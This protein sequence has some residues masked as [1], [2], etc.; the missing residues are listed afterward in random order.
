MFRFL[1]KFI[2]YK[3]IGWRIT[4]RFPKEIKKYIIIVAPH[5][6]GLDFF[7]G[8]LVRSILPEIGKAKYLGKKELF[9]PPLGWIFKATGGYPVDRSKHG[10][11][12]DSIVDIFENKEEF[13]IA[14]A[15][16]GTR[17]RV[18]KLKTGFYY[19]AQKASI[20]IVMVG[21]DYKKKEVIVN[22]PLQTSENF[23]V[24]MTIIMSFF[25]GITGKIPQNGLS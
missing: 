14:L 16:E 5:T 22:E 21:F 11:L 6:S 12:V 8:I 10:N 20:P 18:E 2:Y 3:L 4:G 7:V 13:V 23:E 9:K 24:D 1:S 15:P 19:I 25:R 17:K